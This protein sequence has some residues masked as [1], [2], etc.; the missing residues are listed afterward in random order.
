MAVLDEH[1][2]EKQRARSG[3]E[4]RND[5][6]A[7]V[8]ARFGMASLLVGVS[9]CSAAGQGPTDPNGNMLGTSGATSYGAGGGA[10]ASG[11]VGP[12]GPVTG[13]I[14]CDVNSVI[15]QRCQVCH[16]AT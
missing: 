7:R 8:M 2:G 4:S 6:M 3:Q 16:G 14:P 9:A 13:S 12:G 10:A 15:K 5:I 11:P 1:A